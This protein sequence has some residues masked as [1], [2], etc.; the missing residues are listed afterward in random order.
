MALGALDVD[1]SERGV[2]AILPDRVRVE[3]AADAL[4]VDAV[5]VSPAV[6]RDDDSTWILRPRTIQVGDVLIVPAALPAPPGALR[7]HDGPAF[8]TGLHVTTAL[9]LEALRDALEEGMPASVLDV[10][11]GSGVLAL[12]ALLKGVPSAVGVDIDAGALRE[13]HENAR[14]NGVEDR[15]RLVL[16]GPD[17]VT[18]VWPLVFANVVAAPLIDMAPIL[19]QRVG[20]GG[21]LV[22]SGIPDTVAPE[23]ERAYRWRGMRRGISDSRGGWTAVVFHAGW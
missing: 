12:S 1:V 15:L 11:T 18:A 23:V 3:D 16:G 21:R 19:A 14:L 9:C 17:A 7:L 13:A 6:G 10:G 2:A 20:S 4:G 22:L 5:T 8:G